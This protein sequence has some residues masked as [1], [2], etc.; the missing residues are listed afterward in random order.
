[1]ETVPWLGLCLSFLIRFNNCISTHF[2]FG[3][4]GINISILSSTIILV[5]TIAGVEEIGSPF[6]KMRLPSS[7][8]ETT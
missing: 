3:S 8:L 1:M 6:R 5:S 4:K 2:S 7:F